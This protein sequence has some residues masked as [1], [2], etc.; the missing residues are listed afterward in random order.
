MTAWAL[1][2]DMQPA[3]TLDR[4]R[5]LALKTE[6]AVLSP[7]AEHTLTALLFDVPEA[8]AWRA[9]AVAWTPTEPLTCS[10]GAIEL[11]QGNPLTIVLPE[12]DDMWL[13]ATPVA[14][15]ALPAVK[16][17]EVGVDATN[18][19]VTGLVTPTGPLP[20]AL[21]PG[22]PIELRVALGPADAP[23]EELVVSWYTSAG[24]LDPGR[25]L[26]SEGALLEAPDA[27]PVRIIAVVRDTG[28]GTGWT[29]ATLGPGAP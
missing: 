14:G 20:A 2:C 21:T 8:I 28:G 16:R 27:G 5:V 26:A 22:S 18:P 15:A 7:G 17:L 3:E 13:E 6:P 25:T 24:T 1:G 11:G 29:E 12:L 9:C 19:E 4:P 23:P 10:T